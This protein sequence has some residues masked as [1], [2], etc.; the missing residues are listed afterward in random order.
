[1]NPVLD[2]VISEDYLRRA[3]CGLLMDDILKNVK[4]ENKEI[5]N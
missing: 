5:Y 3:S 1:L 4:M 2:G